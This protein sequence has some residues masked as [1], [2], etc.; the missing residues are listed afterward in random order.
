MRPLFFLSHDVDCSEFFC[1][2]TEIFGVSITNEYFKNH[3]EGFPIKIY[4]KSG[5]TLLI[6]VTPEQIKSQLSKIQEYKTNKGL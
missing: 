5:N 4:A 3:P 1:S 2:Y 6:E